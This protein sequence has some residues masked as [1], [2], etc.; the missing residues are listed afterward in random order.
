MKPGCLALDGRSI[1]RNACDKHGA[2]S[3]E[4]VHSHIMCVCMYTSAR[5][6]TLDGGGDSDYIQNKGEIKKNGQPR[7]N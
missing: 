4:P 3:P 5:T 1:Q 2:Y 6:R 7:K